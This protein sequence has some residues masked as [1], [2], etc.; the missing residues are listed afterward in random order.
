MIKPTIRSQT[1]C[2][3]SAAQRASFIPSVLILA[4]IPP[5]LR[6]NSPLV[7]DKFSAEGRKKSEVLM[8]FLS[9]FSPLEGSETR[10][11]AK[12]RCINK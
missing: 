5:P 11:K 4:T 10:N 2:P 1:Q 8:Y 6:Q 9:F 3:P 7:I 12:T